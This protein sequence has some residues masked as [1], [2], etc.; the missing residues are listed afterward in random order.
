[1]ALAY[2]ELTDPERAVWH[3]V[4]NG[5]LVELP[6]SAPAEDDPANGPT[7]GED[8]RVRAQLI[9]ELLTER[10][11]PKDTPPR[12]IKLAGARITGALDLDAATLVCPLMLRRCSFEQPIRLSEAE[13]IAIRL[14][15][16]HVLGLVTD[17]DDDGRVHAELRLEPARR[18]TGREGRCK[19]SGG[20]RG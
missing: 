1:M 15:G 12:A 3:A 10:T 2:K 9:Y 5:A 11:G 16:C 4:A 7:W 14:P 6:L 19:R 13:A 8:R 17:R 18:L 20:G